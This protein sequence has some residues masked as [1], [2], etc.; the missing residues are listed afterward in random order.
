MFGYSEGLGIL[1]QQ[2]IV[3]LV[4][5]VAVSM[6]LTPV[7]LLLYEKTIFGFLESKI[8]K[9][10]TEQDIHK[11]ENPVIICGFGRFGNMLGRFLR[12]NGVPITILDFDADRVE[13]LGR[14]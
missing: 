14:A 4:A 5:C 13:M 9:K 7:L 10:Q 8:P 6:A 3:I 12:S 11:Q 2:T 1:D